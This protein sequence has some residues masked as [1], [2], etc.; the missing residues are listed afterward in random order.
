MEGRGDDRGGG[1]DDA[2]FDAVG[3]EEEGAAVG[4]RE[5]GDF[6]GGV[7]GVFQ[8]DAGLGS[9]GAA[10]GDGTETVETVL[11]FCGVGGLNFPAG[12]FDVQSAMAVPRP[13]LT[14]EGEAVAGVAET[15]RRRRPA[16]SASPVPSR[17]TSH[18]SGSW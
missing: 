14:D 2:E 10:E 9:G 11:E 18:R 1:I 5:E 12:G 17:A 4:L 13:R 6:D 16:S 8:D 7:G 3:E 15:T